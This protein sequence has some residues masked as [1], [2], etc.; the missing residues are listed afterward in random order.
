MKK[1]TILVVGTGRSGTSFVAQTCHED[2]GI[3]MGHYLLQ[4][5]IMSPDGFY[6][7]LLSHGLLHKILH[8]NFSLEECLYHINK[9]HENCELWGFKSSLTLYL[10]MALLAYLEPK[11]IIRT[12]RPLEDTI[13]SCLK[14]DTLHK[15][16]TTK[17]SAKSYRDLY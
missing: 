9:S 3:C 4:P 17:E 11:L 13:V 10:P 8:S 15:I 6:E 16:I 7:D 1:P 12:W 2:L 5:S 14:N